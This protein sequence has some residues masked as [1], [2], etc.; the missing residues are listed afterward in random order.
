MTDCCFQYCGVQVQSLSL[1]KLS[2]YI[3]KWLDFHVFSDKE[4]K[5]EIPSHNP[6][7]STLWD[8]KEPTHSSQRVG[9]GVPGVVV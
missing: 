3:S 5:P 6:C 9:H 2:N 4:Y 1:H 8:V 7:A